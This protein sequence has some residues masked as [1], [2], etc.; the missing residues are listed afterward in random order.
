LSLAWWRASAP[1]PCQDRLADRRL[2]SSRPDQGA[3]L[4]IAGSSRMADVRITGHSREPAGRSGLMLPRH[5]RSHHSQAPPNPTRQDGPAVLKLSRKRGARNLLRIDKVLLRQN[6]CRVCRRQT[7][8]VRQTAG[9]CELCRC[10]PSG[11]SPAPELNG[12]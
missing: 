3:K 8:V 12:Y 7:P 6:Q 1:P 10:V 4:D 5:L 11:A 2:R 9:A